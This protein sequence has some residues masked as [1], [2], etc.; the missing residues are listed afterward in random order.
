MLLK[1]IKNQLPSKFYESIKFKE[2]NPPQEKAIKAGLLQGKNILV[3]APTASGKTLIAEMAMLKQILENGG[4]AIYTVPLKALAMEKFRDFKN[5]YESL[6]I[7]IALSIGD[8]DSADNYLQNY[9]IIICSNEKLD[10]L[11]RHYAEWLKQVRVVVI[12][13]IH[14]LNETDRGPT[15]EVVITMLNKMLQAQ[16]IALSATIGNP[17]EL[18]EWLQAELVRDE[19]RPI[20]LYEGINL[21]DTID[22]FGEKKGY[23][24]NRITKD[25]VIDLALHTIKEGKQAL[26]FVNSKR[27]A[28]SVAENLAK[29]INSPLQEADADKIL[30]SLS[31]PTKQCEKLASCVKKGIAFHHSGLAPKQRNLIEDSFKNGKIKVICC[32]TTLALGLEFPTDRTIIRD[33]RRFSGYSSVWIP[34]LEMKQFTGRAGRP[35]YHKEGEAICI[36]K[37]EQE[38]ET[39]Y[40]KYI[41]GEPEE[42]YSKLALEPVLRM[43]ILSLIAIAFTKTKQQLREFF[44]DTFWAFQYGDI[45]KIEAKLDRILKVLQKYGFIIESKG[46]LK[47]TNLGVRVSQ[48]YIDPLTAH[49]LIKCIEQAA[50]EKDNARKLTEI[51][52]MQ[53]ISETVEM[54]P[55]LKVRQNEY[56]EINEEILKNE[57]LLYSRP[58]FIDE[59]Y[60]NS[61]KTALMFKDWLN[62]KSEEYLLEEYK[63][64]PGELLVKIH[65]ADWLLYSFEQLAILLGRKEILTD[66]AKLRIRLKYGAKEELLPLIRFKHIGRIRSRTLYNA[67]IRNARDVKTTSLEKLSL[68]LKSK[69]IAKKLKEQVE[70]K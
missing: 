42:I 7:R 61:F 33:L 9:D 58:D 19:W 34:V 53:A 40:E 54:R 66:I 15:L 52:I 68:V 4:K 27:S 63:I 17:E 47:A 30:S 59:F 67:G 2:L 18:A 39:I 36:A 50:V 16:F 70:V 32:T 48:L 57:D 10:S 8:F 24:I 14:L 45:E 1:E 35:T 21:H 41:L 11:I 60:L 25:S 29:I 37:T 38:K 23:A 31:H 3:C 13:E 65:N 46:T 51:G 62:E 20:K 5:K 49:H 43:Y 55:L 28:E 26:V 44:E 12:D 69:E 22:F 6:G 64:R 56:E